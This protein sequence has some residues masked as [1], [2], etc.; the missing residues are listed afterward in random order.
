MVSESWISQGDL[1]EGY[2][3]SAGA[4]KHSWSQDLHHFTSKTKGIFLKTSLN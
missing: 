1:Q 2:G 3:T 4:S